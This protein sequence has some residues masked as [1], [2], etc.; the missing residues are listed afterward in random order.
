MKGSCKGRESA[1][2]FEDSGFRVVGL[3]FQGVQRQWR[4]LKSSRQG[5]LAVIKGL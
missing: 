4:A 1:V 5:F 2:E 3:G